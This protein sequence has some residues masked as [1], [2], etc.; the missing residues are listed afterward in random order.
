MSGRASETAN[1]TQ[2]GF[3]SSIAPQ[4]EREARAPLSPEGYTPGPRSAS[5]VRAGR[6]LPGYGKRILLV[7]PQPFFTLRG[8]PINVRQMASVL[9]RAGYEV[10]LATF[11]PGD[12]VSIPGVTHHRAVQIPGLTEVPIGFSVSKVL[13]DA[14]LALLVTRL[15]LTRRFHLAHA[16]EESVFFTLPLA[17]ARGIPV[18]FDLD[19]SISDQL[20]YTG[21]VRNPVMVRLVRTLEAAAL[22]RSTLAITVCTSLSESVRELSPTTPIAQI[23]DSPQDGASRPPVPEQLAELRQRWNPEGRPLAVY[24]GNFASYQGLS[25]LFSSLPHASRICPEL[26]LLIVGG[27][28]DEIA[29]TRNELEAHNVAHLVSFA[30]RQPPEHMAEYLALGDA[31]VSPRSEGTNTP[32]KLYDYMASGRP[33]VATRLP[34]HTQVLDDSS[35]MLA[36]ADPKSFGEALGRV[37][38]D[39][40]GHAALG[41]AA[42]ELVREEYSAAAFERKLLAAYRRVLDDSAAEPARAFSATTSSM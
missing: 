35:A 20:S 41:R 29:R 7:A 18:I 13:H 21:V 6:H 15:L 33:I 28:S 25:L 39:P 27:T 17:R 12:P 8:T 22:R 26:R 4:V 24:T 16:V 32:L 31:V 19:S 37:L 14:A 1:T 36:E 2:T 10:H 34:T 3:S 40:A 9:G 30:G 23:E 11:A 5:A 38:A 42:Q